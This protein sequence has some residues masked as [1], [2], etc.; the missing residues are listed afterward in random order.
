M[1][2]NSAPNV[3]SISSP[4]LPD[5]STMTPMRGKSSFFQTR[6]DDAAGQVARFGGHQVGVFGTSRARKVAE[7]AS[8]SRCGSGALLV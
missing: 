1:V 3:A 4:T 6:Q 5:V 2:V 7:D 8:A